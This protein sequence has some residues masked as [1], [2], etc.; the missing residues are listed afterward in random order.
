MAL[1]IRNFSVPLGSRRSWK[2][3]VAAARNKESML[4]VL[5]K[6]ELEAEAHST[7]KEA[8]F[9]RLDK[10]YGAALKRLSSNLGDC[11]GV[12]EVVRALERRGR[13]LS[14]QSY[15][16]AM[17]GC[18]QSVCHDAVLH[19]FDSMQKAGVRPDAVAVTAA[20]TAYGRDYDWRSAVKLLEKMKRAGMKPTVVCYTAA[21]S[22]CGRCGRAQEALR[23]QRE[24]L[25]T[26]REQCAGSGGS[27]RAAERRALRAR[28]HSQ[29]MAFT[30]PFAARPSSRATGCRTSGRATSSMRRVLKRSG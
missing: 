9:R 17:R 12:V 8:A 24:R 3:R 6:A 27:M 4:C 23:A 22:A 29:T 13:S 7:N 14:T 25:A 2:E 15:N 5:R 18:L 30:V 10:I 1:R 16:L 19:I 26:A 28:P 11:T 20:L 21:V